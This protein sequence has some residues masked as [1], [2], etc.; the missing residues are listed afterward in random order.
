MRL[1]DGRV[2]PAF[3]G[4]SLRGENLT[5][6]GDGS[7]TRSFCYI[8]DLVD[9]IHKLLISDYSFPVNIGN[10][11]EITISQF[12]E[13]IINLTG[14]DQKVVYSELPINDPLKRKPDITKAQHLL[15][16]EPKVDR[17]EGLKLTLDW[18]K[19]LPSDILNNKEHRD[20][21]EYKKN[22]ETDNI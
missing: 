15:K 21:I 13:E 17:S 18:F 14:T 8:D 16:W 11:N 22:H 7:Q 5:V 12:A 6:F 4:Q 2:L 1:N 10:P 9:G 19:K 20:F 3:I